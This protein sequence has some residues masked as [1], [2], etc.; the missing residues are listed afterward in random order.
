MKDLISQVNTVHAWFLKIA[1]NQLV[2]MCVYGGGLMIMASDQTF[3][4]QIKH[5]SGQIKFGQTNEVTVFAFLCVCACVLVHVPLRV[6]ITNDVM[7]HD[8]DPI[9]SS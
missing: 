6:L 1:R 3:S 9:C 7:W 4:G 2:C 8:M 5:L